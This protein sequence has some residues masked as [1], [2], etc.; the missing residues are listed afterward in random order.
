MFGKKSF[1][2][3]LTFDF[4]ERLRERLRVG[5]L[6]GMG[7]RRS[8]IDEVASLVEEWVLPLI[9]LTSSKVLALDKTKN[10]FFTCHDF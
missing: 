1:Y 3:L 6:A 4:V 10:N 2:L 9:P 8:V 5:A 7:E